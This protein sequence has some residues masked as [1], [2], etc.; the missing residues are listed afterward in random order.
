[1]AEVHNKGSN[2][3]PR[4]G[5]Q[6]AKVG[7]TFLIPIASASASAPRGGW[8]A[9]VHALTE[10]GLQAGALACA[11]GE[12]SREH[13]DLI[14]SQPREVMNVAEEEAEVHLRAAPSRG[15]PRS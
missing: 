12:L 11:G 7:T 2:Q 1:M 3:W 10:A 8:R 14:S 6:C 4:Q 9:S 15:A 5:Q 13:D